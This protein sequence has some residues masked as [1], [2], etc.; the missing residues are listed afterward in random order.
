VEFELT[1]SSRLAATDDSDWL[2]Q[3]I[4]LAEHHYSHAV[5]V[6]TGQL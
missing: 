5:S 6:P 2:A 1:T 3:R 4:I